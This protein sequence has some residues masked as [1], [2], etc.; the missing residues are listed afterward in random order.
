MKDKIK[1]IGSTLFDVVKFI[2]ILVVIYYLLDSCDKN[3]ETKNNL[4]FKKD[5]IK[6][7]NETI[8][9]DDFVEYVEDDGE[10]DSV[11][12][13]EYLNEICKAKEE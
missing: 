8:T 13:E 5:Y 4:K 1:E 10:F 9:F 3:E 2:L 6:V 7:C 11:A 12:F